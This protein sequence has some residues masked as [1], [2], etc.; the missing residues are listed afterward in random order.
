MDVV[1]AKKRIQ[2]LAQ[3]LTSTSKTLAQTTTLVLLAVILLSPSCS[4]NAADLTGLPREHKIQLDDLE[5]QSD[6]EI[7]EHDP[8]LDELRTL[9]TEIVDLLDLP[10]PKRPVIVFLF[11]DEERYRNYMNR[12]HPN[13]PARRAFFI[14]TPTE[15][16]VYA[17]WS[18]QVGEDLRHEYTHGILH[19][20]L[21]TVPLWLDEGLAEYFETQ[22]RD[23]E[24]R[25]PEHLQRISLALKNGWRPDLERLEQIESVNEMQRAD[26]QEAWA[27]IHYLLHDAPDGR[28][29]LIDYC[30]T[31]QKSD[32]PPR[33]T[34]LL[35]D[36]FPDADVRLAS[37]LTFSLVE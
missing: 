26:Y 7:D 27:W 10:P 5:I 21:R 18:D 23:S 4:R 33:F 3:R 9:R 22:S 8:L 17:H 11:G 19:A 32:K 2:V 14:G 31:L 29:L 35:K 13:L 1:I 24:R 16:G 37:Y 25:H 34:T 30:K 15:L 6:L 20:S 36:Y 12:T 28:A